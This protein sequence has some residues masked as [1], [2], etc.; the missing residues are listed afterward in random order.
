M[1]HKDVLYGWTDGPKFYI[2]AID[3]KSANY[4]KYKGKER[5][6]FS[7]SYCF[8]FSFFFSSASRR[9]FALL[10]ATSS[11]LLGPTK[12]ITCVRFSSEC[13]FVSSADGR[14]WQWDLEPAR[15]V[16]AITGNEEKE[17]E[18]KSR[19]KGGNE[20]TRRAAEEKKRNESRGR[21]AEKRGKSKEKHRRKS[22]ENE[23][24][25]DSI[26]LLVLIR[27]ARVVQ[28][29]LTAMALARSSCTSSKCFSAPS[30]SSIR[31]PSWMIMRSEQREC[32]AQ[33]P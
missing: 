11:S 31:F 13:M 28:C 1:I 9:F 14:F 5:T 24:G 19:G 20:E 32:T 3:L 12:K 22:K 33:L 25:S 27:L 10:N 6:F 16:T 8:C 21:A 30:E 26:N 23:Q 7:C 18:G 29:L 15:C 17:K 2:A 4:I